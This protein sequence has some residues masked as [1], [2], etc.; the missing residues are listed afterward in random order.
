[1]G[2]GVGHDHDVDRHSRVTS[3]LAKRQTGGLSGLDRKRN[4][5]H[6]SAYAI[7]HVR[8]AAP[9]FGDH[10]SDREQ[11]CAVLARRAQ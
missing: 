1:V 3:H 4:Q 6:G 5:R 10:R 8:S 11:L 9:P 7:P 2:G